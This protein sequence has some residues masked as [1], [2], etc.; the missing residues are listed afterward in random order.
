ME[1]KSGTDGK[2]VEVSIVPVV[3]FSFNT[4]SFAIQKPDKAKLYIKQCNLCTEMSKKYSVM[5][6]QSEG[7]QLNKTKQ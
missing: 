5:Q 3:A 6:F 7:R 2:D 4:F 1:K